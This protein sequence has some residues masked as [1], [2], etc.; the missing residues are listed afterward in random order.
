MARAG[1]G[2]VPK[3]WIGLEA[4]RPPLL[5]PGPL[6]RYSLPPYPH[7]RSISGRSGAHEGLLD[8]LVGARREHPERAR[9]G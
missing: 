7:G 4:P 3:A 8:V 6:R 9:A 5:V 1:D 2:R